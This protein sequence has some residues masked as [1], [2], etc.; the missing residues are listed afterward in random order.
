MLGKKL[1]LNMIE[2][3]VKKFAILPKKVVFSVKKYRINELSFWKF[4]IEKNIFA[5]ILNL[6][7]NPARSL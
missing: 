3:F 5:A 2:K 1:D 4:Q 7:E 6:A